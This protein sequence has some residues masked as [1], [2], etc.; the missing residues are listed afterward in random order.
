MV[1]IITLEIR[2]I[3]KG[4]IDRHVVP[5]LEVRAS[6]CNDIVHITDLHAIRS[7]TNLFDCLCTVENGVDPADSGPIYFHVI[8]ITFLSAIVWSIGAAVFLLLPIYIY[9]G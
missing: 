3:L 4:L 8:E 9:L 7:L 1:F 2:D 5:L 6:K